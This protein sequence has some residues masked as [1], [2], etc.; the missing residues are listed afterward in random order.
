MNTM[1]IQGKEYLYTVTPKY[2]GMLH[3]KN[4]VVGYTIRISYNDGE[5]FTYESLLTKEADA[6]REARME[7]MTI[8]RF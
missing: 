7:F 8:P 4:V 1:K 2:V 3:S 5:V 6:V